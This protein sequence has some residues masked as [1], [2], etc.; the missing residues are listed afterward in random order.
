MGVQPSVDIVEEQLKTRF[1]ASKTML[2]GSRIIRPQ[3]TLLISAVLCLIG[4][5]TAINLPSS[6]QEYVWSSMYDVAVK[7]YGDKDYQ[8]AEKLFLEAVEEAEKLPK[9]GK[10]LL[11]T[12]QM[13]RKVYISMNKQAL[14]EQISTK[15][16]ALGGKPEEMDETSVHE[17]ASERRPEKASGAA[18]SKPESDRIS[19]D[20]VDKADKKE[21]NENSADDSKGML[22]EQPDDSQSAADSDKDREP[23]KVAAASI[24]LAGEMQSTTTVKRAKEILKLTGHCGWTKS[25]DVSPDS[26][27]VISG[28]ADNTIRLW[29]LT[30][31]KEIG[32]FDGHE[33]AINCV[34]FSPSG[35]TALSGS[36]DKT[37]RLWD[38]DSGTEIKKF[39]GHINLVTCVAFSPVGTKIA[40][41]GYDSTIRIWDTSTGKEVQR[42]QSTGTVRCLA[43]TPDGEQIV[44]GGSDRL[45]TLWRV[46]DGMKVRSFAGHKGEISSIAVSLD[47]T[48][49]LSSSRDIT[50]RVWDLA[51]GDELKCL[52]G[53]G[54]WIQ[55]A[56][57]IS[58]DKAISGS[59]DKTFRIW[60][61]DAGKEIRSFT[62]LHYG[63]WALA[64]TENGDRAITG[65]DDFSLRV[66]LLK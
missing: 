59:L 7:V 16:Q 64:F 49:I 24:G 55:K 41:S 5:C 50:I 65:S 25:I 40:S 44:S 13:L 32:R 37:V 9:E 18:Q 61:L 35:N 62:I 26:S 60:D 43:F 36:S 57:F 11:K 29:D 3:T 12:L 6:A 45:L 2:R 38:L 51:S 42:I 54:N 58:V 39:V 22:R 21:T 20:N 19:T 46:K 63:M 4:L 23:Q 31:G 8:K 14:A 34:V 52:V 10:Q 66:W 27:Q 56:N 33:D 48:R 53:H 47:G 1:K 15:I 17:A 30:T 28:S